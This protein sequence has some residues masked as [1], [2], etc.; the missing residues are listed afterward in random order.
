[1]GYDDIQEEYGISD[2]VF[3]SEDQRPTPATGF[4]YPTEDGAEAPAPDTVDLAAIR[5]ARAAGMDALLRY[6]ASGCETPERVGR[7]ALL[8]YALAH[9][10]PTQR[11]L[12]ER[13][14]L[15]RSRISELSTQLKATLPTLAK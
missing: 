8:I 6:L 1:M 13:L 2:M 3:F 11:E 10:G 12:A 4:T 5:R 14:G 15:S 9:P 7:K